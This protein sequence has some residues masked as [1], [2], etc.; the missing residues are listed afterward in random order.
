[1]AFLV[2]LDLPCSH[3]DTLRVAALLARTT[4]EAPRVVHISDPPATLG[5]LGELYTL[6][7]PLRASGIRV[8]VLTVQGD[9]AAGICRSATELRCR[10]VLLGTGRDPTDASS[11]AHRVMRQCPVPVVAVRPGPLAPCQDTVRDVILTGNGEPTGGA[12]RAVASLLAEACDVPL[13]EVSGT[14]LHSGSPLSRTGA[15][16]ARMVV[17]PLDADRPAPSWALGLLGIEPGTMVAVSRRP[18]LRDV[19]YPTGSG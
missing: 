3:P 17:V 15:S 5:Q 14:S 12:P 7:A 13:R 19:C 1:M 18:F 11:L 16:S 10:W 4:G 9:A 8:H 6:V 2:A